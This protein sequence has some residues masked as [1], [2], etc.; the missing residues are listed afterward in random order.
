MHAQIIKHQRT[1]K[2]C[3]NVVATSSLSKFFSCRHRIGV[4]A[5]AVLVFLGLAS[6]A[7]GLPLLQDSTR[8]GGGMQPKRQDPAGACQDEPT[9]SQQHSVLR[10]D[11]RRVKLPRS[12]RGYAD[13][14]DLQRVP[15][16]QRRELTAAWRER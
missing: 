2:F 12:R 11:N 7:W 9:H 10:V 13:G 16:C 4:A 14:C 5:M 15:N 1:S 6:S 8:P 3:G